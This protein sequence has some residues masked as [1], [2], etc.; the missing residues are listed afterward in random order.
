MGGLGELYRG[1]LFRAENLA[2]GKEGGGAGDASV[3]VRASP[4]YTEP[5]KRDGRAPLVH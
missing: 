2:A 3:C 4:T 5:V 1:I